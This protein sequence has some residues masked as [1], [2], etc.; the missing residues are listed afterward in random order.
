[1]SKTRQG[2]LSKFTSDTNSEFNTKKI[3][4]ID[5]IQIAFVQELKRFIG[6]CL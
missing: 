4:K 3:N 6:K 1:M 2:T 5:P